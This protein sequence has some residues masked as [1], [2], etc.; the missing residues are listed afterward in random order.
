MKY[1]ISLLL[2]ILFSCTDPYNSEPKYRVRNLAT[3]DITFLLYNN[4]NTV[5]NLQLAPNNAE[6]GDGGGQLDVDS[7]RFIRGN[8]STLYINPVV[9]K[10]HYIDHEERNFFNVDNWKKDGNDYFYDVLDSDF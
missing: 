4:G 2:L 1:L 7:V 10:D 3:E 6:D 5:A 9:D 8:D